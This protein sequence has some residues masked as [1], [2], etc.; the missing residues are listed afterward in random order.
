MWLPFTAEQRTGRD[1]FEWDARVGAGPLTLLRVTDRFANGTGSTQGRLFGVACVFASDDEHTARS[2]AGRAALEAAAFAP[3]TLLPGNGVHWRAE[4][5]TRIVACWPVGPEI[6][7][8]TI[9]IDEDG[10]A[11]TISAPR[12]RAVGGDHAY[13]PCGCEIDAHRRF[14]DAVLPSRITVAWWFGTPCQRPFFRAQIDSWA[15]ARW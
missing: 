14:G 15:P 2:A 11:H 4:S 12:W 9:D 3:A 10:A 1:S 5:D 6:P 7:E 13:V 8:V